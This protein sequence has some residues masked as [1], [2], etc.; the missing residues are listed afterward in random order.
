MRLAA[1]YGGALETELEP[2]R[3][4][5]AR[6]SELVISEHLRLGYVQAVEVCSALCAGRR[7]KEGSM[8]TTTFPE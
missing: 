2:G 8:R 1:P 4:D 7:R 3:A 6:Y 5:S